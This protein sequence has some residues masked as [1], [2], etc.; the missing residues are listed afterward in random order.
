MHK[1]KLAQKVQTEI[2]AL[3]VETN[4]KG[5]RAKVF[6]YC[7]EVVCPESGWKVPLL[8]TLIIS[9]GYKV[10]T[11]LVPVPAEKRYDVEVIYVETDAEVEAAKIGTVQEGNLVHSPGGQTV[12]R[13]SINNI[14]GDYKD[15]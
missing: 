6:L 2:D 14:R 5:W 4:G 10:I 1:K 9:K 3:G 8:P 11:K 15:G 12:Y 7:V 13:V